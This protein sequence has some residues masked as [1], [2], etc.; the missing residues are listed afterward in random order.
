MKLVL[1]STTVSIRLVTDTTDGMTDDRASVKA[2]TAAV[3]T[4]ILWA[5]QPTSVCSPTLRPV[6]VAIDATPPMPCH[7]AAVAKAL[8]VE[9]PAAISLFAV[10]VTHT[11]LLAST[12]AGFPASKIEATISGGPLNLGSAMVAGYRAEAIEPAASDATFETD[13]RP[14]APANPARCPA[15]SVAVAR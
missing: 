14:C 11:A 7:C 3:V 2:S 4:P 1:Y 13:A 15:C 10:S 6:L 8:T 9:R 12:D 5:V